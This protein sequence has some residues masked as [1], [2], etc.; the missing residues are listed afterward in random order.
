MQ[1]SDKPSFSLEWEKACNRVKDGLKKLGKDIP[2]TAY[3][4][5]NNL[6]KVGQI[7]R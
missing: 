1:Y 2:I 5:Y 4:E 7:E 6:F 3:T